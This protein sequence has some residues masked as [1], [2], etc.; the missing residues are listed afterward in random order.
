MY[1]EN[2]HSF[3]FWGKVLPLGHEKRSNG[4]DFCQRIKTKLPDFKGIFGNCHT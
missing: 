1:T 3:F 4:K 2:S